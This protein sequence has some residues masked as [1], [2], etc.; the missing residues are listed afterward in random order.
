MPSDVLQTLV[1]VLL[2][3][4]LVSV[5]A[6]SIMPLLVTVA[7][8]WV[9]YHVA[10]GLYGCGGSFRE[11]QLNPSILREISWEPLRRSALD[12]S[13]PRRPRCNEASM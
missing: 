3:G 10:C 4:I 12:R 9:G 2:A 11:S 1:S 8:C 5:L 6:S 7:V 13:P